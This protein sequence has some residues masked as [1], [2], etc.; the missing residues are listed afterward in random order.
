MK[1]TLLLSFLLSGTL[2]IQAQSVTKYTTTENASWQKAKASLTTKADGKLVATINGN[3]TGTTFRAWGTT[4]NEL[5]WDAF[6]LLSRN[7]QDEVMRNLFAKDGDLRF[8]H[9]RVS[10][11]ANDYA[12]SWYQC[13]DVVGDLSHESVESTRMDEDQP[14]LLCAEQSVQYPAEG[15]GL[16][17]L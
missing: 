1:R 7:D 14:R 2:A 8:T 13:D 4:F 15:K 10:M 11:N 17:A 12:R 3:E 9:G 5:D 16:S 6:N